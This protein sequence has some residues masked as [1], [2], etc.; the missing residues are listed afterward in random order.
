MQRRVVYECFIEQYG[1]VSLRTLRDKLEQSI[2]SCKDTRWIL[3]IGEQNSVM[4]T[5][6]HDTDVITEIGICTEDM[7]FDLYANAREAAAILNKSGYWEKAAL[8]PERVKRRLQ[9][10][11]EAVGDYELFLVNSSI[12]SDRFLEFGLFNIRICGQN[13][14]VFQ[15][16][17][18]GGQDC[19][20]RSVRIDVGAEV[21]QLR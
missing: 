10:W 19:D 2:P 4:T 8:E 9:Q 16:R 6:Y 11:N 5:M 12:V 3:R 13:R 15:A 17:S 21:D 20:R 18:Q 7:R 14:D 1:D